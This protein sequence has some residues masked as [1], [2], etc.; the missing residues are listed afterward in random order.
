[1]QFG[2]HLP[3]IS[4][5]GEPYSLERLIAYTEASNRLGYTTLC[6]NDHL[7]FSK[8]WLDGP[9]ALACVVAHSGQMSLATTVSVPVI[10][11]PIAFAKVVAALDI[12]SGGRLNIGVGPGS[13]QRDYEIVG[14]PFEERWKRID[15]AIPALRS[16][17]QKD[18]SP[19]KG[20]FY[21]TE[22]IELEP[23]PSSGSAPPIWIGSWG[24]PVGLRRVARLADGWLASG[25]N[26]TP[27]LFKESLER[28]NRYV[29]DVGKDSGNFPN[30]IATMFCYITEDQK[31]AQ[32]IIREII[33]PTL[34]R[35]EEELKERLL[36]GSA[37]E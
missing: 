29:S 9:M 35:P 33:G 13:S 25:Y 5:S 37:Q 11:G 31:K 15:E 3:L 24:S 21:D 19:F 10:R 28:L 26:T 27:S 34:N 2:A 14:I 17:L 23:F 22:G 1:M 4:F 36:V 16:L 30:A 18:M 32:D 12:M 20:Q 6:A 7:I 8:P